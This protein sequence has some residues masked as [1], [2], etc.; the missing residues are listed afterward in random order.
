MPD[1]P[2]SVSVPDLDFLA[3]N[4]LFVCHLIPASHVHACTHMHTH[5]H[6]RAHTPFHR[7]QNLIPLIGGAIRRPGNPSVDSRALRRAAGCPHGGKAAT[8]GSSGAFAPA[9]RPIAAGLGKLSVF[10]RC[11]MLASGSTGFRQQCGVQ[12]QKGLHW[13]T[14][15]VTHTH[16]H[17]YDDRDGPSGH[18]AV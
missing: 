16:A 12:G 18:H 1:Y 15:H 2:V 10:R 5:T 4:I 17:K 13:N 8:P 11:E 3:I 14:D 7:P 6:T 9:V